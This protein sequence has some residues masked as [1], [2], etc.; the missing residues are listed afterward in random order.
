MN[1]DTKK[2]YHFKLFMFTIN[3][4]YKCSQIM[5]NFGNKNNDI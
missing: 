4:F 3:I 2:F 5:I 1:N